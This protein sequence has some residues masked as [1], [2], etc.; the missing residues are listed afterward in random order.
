MF[1]FNV[2]LCC[3]GWKSFWTVSTLFLKVTLNVFQALY[4]L[5]WFCMSNQQGK[6]R[7][8]QFTCRSGNAVSLDIVMWLGGERGGLRIAPGL[9]IWDLSPCYLNR[10][11]SPDGEWHSFIHLFIQLFTPSMTSRRCLLYARPCDTL[12]MWIRRHIC[13]IHCKHFLEF[14]KHS[15]DLILALRK[16]SLRD[17]NNRWAWR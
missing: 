2:Q 15:S 5:P 11:Q 6:K 3:C 4:C 8:Y 9:F 17:K 13:R 10:G 12:W 16:I 1:S 7:H 14:E